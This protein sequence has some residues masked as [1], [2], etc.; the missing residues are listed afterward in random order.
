[1]ESRSILPTTLKLIFTA[2]VEGRNT[3]EPSGVGVASSTEALTSS[4]TS[5]RV[6]VGVLVTSSLAG[7]LG[8]GATSTFAS[9][10]GSGLGSASG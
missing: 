9:D 5:A 7:A 8:V 6:G 10:L 3:S 2:A 4:L 1:M